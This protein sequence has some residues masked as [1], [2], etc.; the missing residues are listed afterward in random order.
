M[1][2]LPID[3]D[4]KRRAAMVAES[5]GL[6]RRLVVGGLVEVWEY[7]WREK[8]DVLTLLYLS[9]CIGPDERLRAGLV[10][11][12]FLEPVD[13][14]FRVRGAKKWLLGMEGKSR[15][16]H[17][18]KS[19]LIPGARQKKSAESQPREVEAP[20]ET[21]SASAESLPRASPDPLSADLSALT[22]ST[23]HPTP[24]KPLKPLEAVA[25]TLAERIGEVFRDATG[26]EFE[27]TPAEE[28]ALA[29]V[30]ARKG[31][32]DEEILRRCGIAFRTR[33][34]RCRGM[35]DLSRHWNAYASPEPTAQPPPGRGRATNADKDWTQRPKTRMTE[36]G[37]ELDFDAA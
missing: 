11:A 17:A 30:L 25:S 31:A 29:A 1:P 22:P 7:V 28:Q 27:W 36:Y 33:F 2:Y 19:N 14:G 9:A 15:G 32:T 37:E 21:L 12:G 4:G 34:P 10:E 5:L 13:G 8:R 23:Q 18:A 6:D 20:P 16:G 3:L 26:Q 24:R 35:A